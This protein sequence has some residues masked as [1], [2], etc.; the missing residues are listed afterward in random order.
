MA[1]SKGRKANVVKVGKKV[2]SEFKGLIPVNVLRVPRID[3][4]GNWSKSPKGEGLK[5]TLCFP[6]DSTVGIKT[7]SKTDPAWIV[8]VDGADLSIQDARAIA[9]GI[10]SLKDTTTGIEY[11]AKT[12]DGMDAIPKDIKKIIISRC[13]RRTAVS[14]LKIACK[15]IKSVAEIQGIGNVF[16]DEEKTELFN[17]PAKW[18]NAM[19]DAL[20]RVKEEKEEEK[21]FSIA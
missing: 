21:F 13:K 12:P 5:D 1:K 15:M 14:R 10:G 6:V 3:S 19:K 17:T 16:T 18:L 4:N 8:T 9:I 20:L 11:A 7:Q 2:Q